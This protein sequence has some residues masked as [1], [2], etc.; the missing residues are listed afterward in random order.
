MR[1]KRKQPQMEYKEF[2]KKVKAAG[3][4][5]KDCGRY[6]WRIEGG[7]YEV[8]WYPRSKGKTIYINGL[9]RRGTQTNGDI[10]TAIR[11][12]KEPP[13][14]KPPD[15]R[16]GRKG[17]YRGVKRK[18]LKISRLCFWCN[19]H[20]SNGKATVD[21]KIPLMRGGSNA[22]DNMVLA[23]DPCNKEKGNNIWVKDKD[24]QV[25]KYQSS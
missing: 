18:L 25:T 7:D 22:Q 24:G 11:L 13:S 10:E 2:E 23:C 3:L 14:I 21:H 17:S 19:A 5:P 4:E 8:N 1:L 9:G 16:T 6:H 15:G 12:A 20:L